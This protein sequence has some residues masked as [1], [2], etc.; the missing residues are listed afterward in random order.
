MPFLPLG[1]GRS[2]TTS[3]A[4]GPQ[5]ESEMPSLSDVTTTALRLGT[6]L[7][8]ADDSAE[9]FYSLTRKGT[10][11]NRVASGG[12]AEMPDNSQAGS[13]SEV[14]AQAASPGDGGP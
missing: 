2:T 10:E 6:S 9:L 1:L 3:L 5:A 4:M 13:T 11:A 7:S 12:T 8:D 14:S